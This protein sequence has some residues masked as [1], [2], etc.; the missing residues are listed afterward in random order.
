MKTEKWSIEEDPVMNKIVPFFECADGFYCGACVLEKP[1]SEQDSCKN[2][3]ELP[4]WLCRTC[5]EKWGK[6]TIEEKWKRAI[7]TTVE[8]FKKIPNNVPTE[9]KWPSNSLSNFIVIRDGAY[10]SFIAYYKEI[11]FPEVIFSKTV[12]ENKSNI[13][14]ILKPV[15]SFKYENNSIKSAWNIIDGEKNDEEEE[16]ETSETNS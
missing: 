2:S 1:D 6:L 14:K 3:K 10:L 5:S 4:N 13:E 9:V 16:E 8:E 12:L 15:L 7:E 11:G